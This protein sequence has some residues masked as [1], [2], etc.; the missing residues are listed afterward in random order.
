VDRPDATPTITKAERED[1]QR[2]VRQREKVLKSAAKLRSDELLADFENQMAAEYRF[3]DDAVWAE[4]AKETEAEVA[5]AQEKIAARCNAL[6]IPRQFAPSLT[7]HWHARGY[8][9]SLDKRRAELRRAAQTQ[10]GAMEQKAIVRIE[11]DSLDAQTQLAIAGLTSDA[12]RTFLEKLPTVESLMPA[13]SYEAVAG[14][15]ATPI[16]EQILTPGALRQRR[17][18]ERLASRDAAKALQAPTRDGD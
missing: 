13:L 1:L 15:S 4:A 16:I 14:E 2:L 10:I 12:A 7:L 9:N 3:D 11:Q 18:R 8:N 5:K 6:G 17:Y